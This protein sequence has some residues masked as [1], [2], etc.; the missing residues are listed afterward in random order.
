MVFDLTTKSDESANN[1][2]YICKFISDFL[3]V[4]S[5]D[6]LRLK[7]EMDKF[8]KTCDD[9]RYVESNLRRVC[10]VHNVKSSL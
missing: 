7:K 10:G 1:H 4:G 9:A 5:M 6:I 8:F 3:M 2:E